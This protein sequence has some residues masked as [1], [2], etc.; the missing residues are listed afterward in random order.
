ME[1]QNKR[2]H[3]VA[4][5]FNLNASNLVPYFNSEY[6][7][8]HMPIALGADRVGDTEFYVGLRQ[9][10]NVSLIQIE[11]SKSDSKIITDVQDDHDS[12]EENLYLMLHII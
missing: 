8:L 4:N 12:G 6:K 7:H 10:N 5:Y 11:E 3:A 1:S 9:S 2:Q